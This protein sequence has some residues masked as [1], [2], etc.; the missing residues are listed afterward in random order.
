M[1]LLSAFIK[2]SIVGASGVVVNLAIYNTLLFNSFFHKHYLVSNAI[3]FMF[4]VTNNFYWNF[5][6]TFYD[7]ASHKSLQSKYVQ[8]FLIGF[9]TLLVNSF[10]LHVLVDF[11]LVNA[12][13][14]NLIAIVLCSVLNFIGNSLLTFYEKK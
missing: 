12:R 10:I 2:F 5:K 13:L 4:A 11:W 14:A 6:W 8:F 1:R 7:R 9:V 3:S